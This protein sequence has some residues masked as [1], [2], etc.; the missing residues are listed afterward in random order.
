MSDG[1]FL[2]TLMQS[3]MTKE[4]LNEVLQNMTMQKQNDWREQM[5]EHFRESAKL[6]GDVF[7]LYEIE[8]IID[9][10]IIE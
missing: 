5:K 8:S 4:Q 3:V 9:G 7:R 10:E 6:D 2:L 1:E